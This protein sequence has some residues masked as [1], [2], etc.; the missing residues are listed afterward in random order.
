MVSHKPSS[1][2]TPDEDLTWCQM[3]IARTCLL[4]HMAQ[5]GWPKPHVIALAEVYLNLES[6][7]MWLQVD[8]DTVLLHHQAQVQHKWHEA[9]WASSEEPAFNISIIN[10]KCVEAIGAD[11][12]NTR[13]T[14]GVLRS[15][16]PFFSLDTQTDGFPS[17]PLFIPS[18]SLWIGIMHPHNLAPLCLFAPMLPPLAAPRT[19]C[20]ILPCTVL[21]PLLHP[22]A[23]V[24]M[25]ALLHPLCSTHAASLS[26]PCC[27]PLYIHMRTDMYIHLYVTS[28]PAPAISPLFPLCF[29][30][31]LMTGWR[32]SWPRLH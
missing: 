18:C 20:F 9:L 22:C 2:V 29:L 4:H 13:H 31:W 6:H 5:T 27:L 16:Q 30:A 28:F 23:H 19:H 1:K 11:I 7:P 3:S 12:W 14:E 8:G 17:P 25:H 26:L 24:F 10:I 15:V 21:H 32:S